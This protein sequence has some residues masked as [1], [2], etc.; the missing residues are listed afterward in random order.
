ML[1]ISSNAVVADATAATK[2]VC[3]LQSPL[4]EC[5]PVP[6]S[7]QD[8]TTTT[9]YLEGGED[10]AAAIS[11]K[12]NAVSRQLGVQL[13]AIAVVTS[14]VRCCRCK[15]HWGAKMR[16]RDRILPCGYLIEDIPPRYLDLKTREKLKGS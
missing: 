10:Y 16:K 12:T 3:V 5:L 8:E 1:E 2:V 14:I 7:G 6:T 11:Q 9:P 15:P 13:G 4:P